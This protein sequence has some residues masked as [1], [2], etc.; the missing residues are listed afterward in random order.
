MDD[1]VPLTGNLARDEKSFAGYWADGAAK[2]ASLP[3]KPQRNAEEA[4]E[5]TRL[6]TAVRAAR[7]RFLSAHAE[8]VYDALT[9]NG[10][11]FVRLEALVYDAAEAFA[12]LTPS[13]LTVDAEAGLDQGDKD[14]AEID[15]GI[16]LAHVLGV[17]RT[18]RHLC[19]AML[20]ALPQSVEAAAKFSA[21]RRL[22]LGPVSLERRGRAVLLTNSNPRFLN[23]E[24][25]TTLEAM[26]VAVDVA[27]L[28]P[29]SEI[30]VMRGGVVE[31][32]K[33]AGRQ[34]LGA[35]INL[36][37]LYRGDIPFEWFMRRDLGF[38]HKLFRGVASPDASP[39]D[40]AGRTAEKPLVTVVEGF[41]I[42]GHCQLLLV[43]DYVL[44][45]A[46]AY[47]TL[48]ARKEGIIPG[49]ANLRLPRFLGDRMARQAIQ[50]ER[51]FDCDSAEGRLLCDEIVDPG[52][53]DAAID[54]VIAGLTNAGAVSAVGNRRAFRIGAEPLD[55]F[56][57]YASVYAREQAYCHFSPALIANL[58]RNWDARSRAV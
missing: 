54:T 7:E 18:G 47:V 15:Q 13:R 2:L 17:P 34:L 1:T 31:H 55:A 46:D 48:P 37:R 45:A 29:H 53:M 41:A 21:D 36:T 23:A 6:K 5:A 9:A 39:D 57:C 24:D 12:G 52:D 28:D 49:M 11:R 8:A 27:I 38:V 40:I 35:G 42:G 44:A 16:F 19:H 14:G 58:E 25:N 56:R 30:I 33:Y 50:Y 43:S 22:D 32:P 10:Q 20:L 51:R 4:A 26:E 3:P